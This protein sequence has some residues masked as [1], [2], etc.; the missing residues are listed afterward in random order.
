M[1]LMHFDVAMTVGSME[2]TEGEDLT[3]LTEPVWVPEMKGP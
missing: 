1:V 2:V 3:W